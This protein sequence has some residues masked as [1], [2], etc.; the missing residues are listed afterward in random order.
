VRS[1][2][3]R[4]RTEPVS[5]D[6]VVNRFRG[7]TQP[8]TTTPALPAGARVPAAGVYAYATTGFEQ[9]ELLGTSRHAYPASTAL[10]VVPGGCGFTSTWQPL[11]KRSERWTTCAGPGT[12]TPTRFD[13]VHSFFGRT[14]QRSYAC[15][16]GPIALSADARPRATTRTCAKPG[17][18]RT[19]RV[20]VVG[21]ERL[22]VGGAEV[23]TVHV[24]TERRTTGATR[25]GGT[26][27]S[28]L[29]RATGLPVRVV[30]ANDNRTDTPIGKPVHY[31]ERYR[32]ELESL[33]PRR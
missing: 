30:V 15:T 13:D 2:V 20:R 5:V 11:D 1:W 27:D 8:T 28:W 10:T 19:D 6:R 24:H 17:T 3:L 16:G 22:T 26:T 23:D 18:T 4:D 9:A 31:V 12:L 25:G 33:E 7:E 29:V 32:L 21:D 14:D